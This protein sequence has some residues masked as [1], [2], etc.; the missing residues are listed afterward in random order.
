[1]EQEKAQNTPGIE[2]APIKPPPDPYVIVQAHLNKITESIKENT[3]ALVEMGVIIRN[4]Q[5]TL[6]HLLKGKNHG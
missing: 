2:G 3:V 5:N 1:M 6:D 4:L